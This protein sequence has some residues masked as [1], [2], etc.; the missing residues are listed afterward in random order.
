MSEPF[1]EVTHHPNETRTLSASIDEAGRLWITDSSAEKGSP[2]NDHLMGFSEVALTQAE[3]QA[4]VNWARDEAKVVDQE[5]S[6][7]LNRLLESVDKLC[8]LTRTKLDEVDHLRSDRLSLERGPVVG[9]GSDF[10]STS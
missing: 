1:E 3:F 9:D 6:R 4:I 5:L 8:Q 10:R 2:D 7:N